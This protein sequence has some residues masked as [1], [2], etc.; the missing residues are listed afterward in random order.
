MTL[1]Q[2]HVLAHYTILGP[3]GAG[4][5]GE[6]YRARDTKLG[7]EVAINVLPEHFA[8]DE[9][10]LKRFERE[11]K[12]LASLNHPNVAQ[13]HGVDQVGDTCFLVLE[14]VPGESLEER[15][16]RGPLPLEEALDVCK[17]I[18]E[19]LEAAHDAGVI[20]RDLKPANVRVTPEGKVKVLDFGLAKTASE[21]GRGSSTDSVLSTEAGR[22]L[23]TPTY[24]APEQARGKSID[25]RV[26]IWA[27]GCVLYECLTAKRAFAGESLTDVLAAVIEREPDF[28][29]LSAATPARVRELLERCFAKDP[30]ARLRDI[31]DARLALEAVGSGE[32][33][34]PVAR[35]SAWL[36]VLPWSVSVLLGIVLVFVVLR[37]GDPSH[38]SES[39]RTARHV[40]LALPDGVELATSRDR[41]LSISPDGTQVVYV[42]LRAGNVQLY[43]RP[44]DR[45]EST[46]IA[47]TDEANSPFFSPDGRWVGFFAHGKLK[48]VTVGGT[49]LQVLADAPSSMGGCW[50]VD[51]TLY[52]AP[53]NLSGLWKVPAA[54]GPATEL[55][56]LEREA[57]EISHHWPHPLPDGKTLLFSI[58]TGPGP[59]EQIIARQSLVSG[60]RGVL[61]T[62][63]S[64]PWFLSPGHL[65]YGRLDA[66]YAT[67]WDPTRASL[68]GA[69]PMTMPVSAQEREGVQAMALS[70]DGTLVHVPAG[71]G[72]RSNRVV[73]VDRAGKVEP[74]AL[75]ER[76]FQSVALSPDG[77][78]AIVQFEEGKSGLWL[79]DLARATLTP[80]ATTDGS[81]QA[82]VWTPDGKRVIYRGTRKGFR[83]LFWKAADGTGAEE[84]LTTK[85][86]VVQTPTSVS[87]DGRWVLFQENTT[88]GGA[89]WRLPLERMASAKTGEPMFLTDG[90]DGQ[91]SPDGQWLAYISVVT[92]RDEIYVQPFPGPGPR[93]PISTGGGVSPL[94]SHDGKEL[95]FETPGELLVV[96][97]TTTPTFSAS[98]PRV[99]YTGRFHDT[100]NGNTPFSITAD[101]QRFLRVQ[102]VEPD[103]PVTHIDLV[104]NWRAMLE[105]A[106]R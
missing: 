28:S 73:W 19:G 97:V 79:C 12:T 51:D 101:G 68:E 65:L 88:A 31:G 1:A 77:R 33:A 76:D 20:H 22:L 95:F 53:T 86:D 48:K 93:V 104:L 75:K 103:R 23:G 14:L 13:I 94:W 69:V 36:P 67:P 63:V 26:D 49:A 30:R 58:W 84:R 5:M 44:L 64:T 92:G 3:L 61:L 85:A 21:S 91:V 90:L 9:E 34:E 106:A 66:L 24:M 54:G 100:G 62:G 43:L 42:G 25:R 59:D 57:G 82:P 35:L 89:I 17:Q 105:Q 11:A 27:F 55:T 45:A 56:R 18:A 40:S 83:N 87:P 72:H 6:V 8:E 7:R 37:G 102:Q 52:F 47:G 10:R 99:L 96:D 38:S 41:P 46:P 81:S 50:G 74:L 98:A 29:R 2:G 78:Q 4:A 15:L 16:K 60:E 80:F 70:S 71:P 32:G 39:G